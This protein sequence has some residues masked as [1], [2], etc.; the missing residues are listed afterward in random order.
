MSLWIYKKDKSGKTILWQIDVALPILIMLLTG[1][2]GALMG[3]KLYGK[4]SIALWVPFI[5]LVV[6]VVLLFISKLSLYRKGIYD[7]FGPGQMTKAYATLYKTAY[8]LL[9]F[10]VLILLF[11][12]NILRKA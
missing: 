7:S 4:P 11:T 6:G 12:W 9:G 10:G 2:M 8:V 3:T 1:F 5:I